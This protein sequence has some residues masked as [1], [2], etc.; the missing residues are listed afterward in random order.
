MNTSKPAPS[1]TQSAAARRGALQRPIAVC[2]A[3]LLGS[4]ILFKSMPTLDLWASSWFYSPGNG[5]YLGK[6]GVIVAIRDLGIAVTVATILGL[7]GVGFW[8]QL[9]PEAMAR[10][11][12]TTPRADWVFITLGLLLG[13]GLVVNLIFKPI[14]GRARPVHIEQFGGIDH[15]TP[16][17]VIAHQC[18]W[19]CAFVS[20]EAAATAFNLALCMITPRPW[21]TTAIAVT[22]VVTLAVSFARMAAGGHFFSDVVTAWLMMTLLLMILHAQIYQGLWLGPLKRWWPIK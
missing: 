12:S 10:W 6:T 9:R 11:P 21:R 8:W 20:G 18:Q 14:W 3:L 7:I 15:F 5:F 1:G 16:A 22:I 17:W 19:N 2:A 4:A 13:P